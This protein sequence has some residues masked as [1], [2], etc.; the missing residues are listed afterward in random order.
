MA[1]GDH[2]LSDLRFEGYTPKQLADQVDALRNGA[3]TSTM[4]DSMRSL[5]RIALNLS[6][7]DV[8]LRD[9]LKE[10]GVTWQGEAADGGT[11]ATQSAAIYAEDSVEP[12]QGSVRGVGEQTDSFHK[13]SNSAPDSGTLRGPTEENGV[14]QFM[15]FFGHT[16]DHAQQVKDTNAAAAAAADAMD[17]YKQSSLSSLAQSQALPVPPGMNLVAQPVDT[18][19]HASSVNAV[20]PTGGLSPTGGGPYAGPYGGPPGTGGPVSPLPT[21]GGTPPVTG[22]P[23]ITGG[24][25]IP[26]NPLPTT[27]NPL[28]QAA[29]RANPMLMADAATMMGSGA[30]GGAG[31]GAERDR[32]VRN[33]AARTPLKNGVPIGAV[34]EEEARAARNAERFGARTGRPG[35]SIMQPAAGARGANGEE[36]QEHVRRYGVES[37]DVFDDERVVAPEA[38]GDDEYDR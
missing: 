30:A 22:A 18:S 28:A 25:P 11:S 27:A 33:T 35:G 2:G 23:P 15:G 17:G 38:I 1:A 12:V 4:Q 34:P 19:T 31:A 21:T 8:A 13:T 6:V 24:G 10:I 3:G 32:L 20:V 29:L 16:T 5:M 7:T 37:S 9:Q 14:D 36:D 26:N